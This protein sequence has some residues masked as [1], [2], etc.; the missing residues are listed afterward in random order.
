M[1]YFESAL[2]NRSSYQVEDFR[3]SSSVAG[4]PSFDI[5]ASNQV[6]ID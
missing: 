5:D 1:K 4:D 6:R 2:Q 3:M